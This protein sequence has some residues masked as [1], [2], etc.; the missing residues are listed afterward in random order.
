MQ[1]LKHMAAGQRSRVAV[2]SRSGSK[3]KRLSK[4]DQLRTVTSL[5]NSPYRQL[6]SIARSLLKTL[7][8]PR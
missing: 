1:N 7:L 6:R 2:S 4:L 8:R 3:E 5:K